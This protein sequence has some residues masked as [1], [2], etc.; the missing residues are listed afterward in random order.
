MS[1]RRLVN[2]PTCGQPNEFVPSNPWRPFCCERCKKIDLGAWASDQYVVA[3]SPLEDTV[4]PDAL[5]G[6]SAPTDTGRGR[7]RQ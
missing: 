5:P 6:E 3:G 4:D 1:A 7:A 2:C